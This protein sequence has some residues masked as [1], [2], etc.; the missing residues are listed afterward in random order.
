[1]KE[2]L[3]TR[4]IKTVPI[5]LPEDD[6][7]VPP[8]PATSSP[9]RSSYGP[10]SSDAS[11]K[12][13]TVVVDRQTEP[14]LAVATS[15]K[16]DRVTLTVITGFNAGQV[17]ALDGTAHTIGRGTEADV[18]V[19]DAGV[20]REHALVTCRSD[21]AYWVEDLESTNGT[22]VAGERVKMRE[23]KSGDRLQLGPSL[24]LRFAV[25]DDAEEELQRRLY[26]SSTKD[27]LTRAFN[28]KYFTERLVAEVAHSRRHRVK[29]SVLMLDV[30]EFKKV[31][32]TYG[33]LV[34]DMVL[35]MV[36]AA[37]A[38][39]IRVEDLLAR[40]G[41]EEFVILARSTGRSDAAIL[42]ERVREAVAAVEVPIGD[43]DPPLSVTISIGVSTLADAGP[44]AGPDELLGLAD[45]RMYMAKEQGR[46]RVISDS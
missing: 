12:T 13:E 43:G 4:R 18:W 42:G 19:E 3:K 40:Y 29:L 35:R 37:I 22:F 46:N 31:N 34:G 23:L 9:G 36:A 21:G 39:L 27:A 17:F 10:P 25:T 28:R 32:D 14:E 44:E 2:P 8:P 20:S 26:E 5:A 15:T 30:D 33:H 41:G 11:W 45:K 38:R 16:K 1:M 6:G 7:S 24:V